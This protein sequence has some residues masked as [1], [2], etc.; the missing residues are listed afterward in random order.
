[1]SATAAPRRASTWLSII[2]G[3]RSAGIVTD[4][5]LLVA[6]IALAWIFI[7]Y[8]ASKLFGWFG[9]PGPKGIHQTAL[10]FSHTAHLHPG[11][12][13]AVVGGLIEFGGGIA[14]ALGLLTRLAGVA[15]FGDMVVAMITVTWAT[16][17]NS[18]T[19]PPGYQLNIAVGVLA[20]VVALI[21][22]G[23]FSVDAVLARRFGIGNADSP[24][25]AFTGARGPQRPTP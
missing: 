22:P 4:V 9:G 14:M 7:Y 12:F 15:L 20:L 10:F 2:F 16:G 21:G 3:T 11:T 18:I 1:M 8:G 25:G 6:R 13:F 24:E 5:G 23:R 17:L 19:S